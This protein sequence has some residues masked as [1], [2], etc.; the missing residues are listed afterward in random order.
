MT[1][2]SARVDLGNRGAA[3]GP[4]SIQRV[5]E[6]W[7]MRVADCPG[8][9]LATIIPPSNLS[10]SAKAS[11]EPARRAFADLTPTQRRFF[12]PLPGDAIVFGGRDRGQPP[13]SPWPNRTSTCPCL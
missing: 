12:A 8:Q 5:G 4:Q 1:P 10:W 6:L 2:D 11:I 9:L 3:I 7:L 13:R